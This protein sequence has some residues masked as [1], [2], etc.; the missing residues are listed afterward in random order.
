[1][2]IREQVIFDI[3]EEKFRYL[4]RDVDSKPKRADMIEL[5]KRLNHIRKMNFYNNTKII[6]FSI[7]FVG[8]FILISFKF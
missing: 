8:F 2:K 7:L 5:N 1:M 3:N 4:Q 6:T